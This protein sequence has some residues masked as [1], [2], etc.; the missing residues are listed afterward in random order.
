MRLRADRMIARYGMPSS[1]RYA[2]LRRSG[3]DRDCTAAEIEFTPSQRHRIV[4]PTA[5]R[6]LIS[7][8]GLDPPPS[9]ADGDSLVIFDATT[10]AEV[11]TL[12]LIQKPGRLAP[13][14]TVVFWDLTVTG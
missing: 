9:R 3:V 12:R 14:G 11:E 13:A 4:D 7:A 2:K 6:F 10:D 8:E 1:T 5:R